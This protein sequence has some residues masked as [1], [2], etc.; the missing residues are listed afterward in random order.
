MGPQGPFFYGLRRRYA[1]RLP[2]FYVARDRGPTCS[3]PSPLDP[4][5][6]WFFCSQH[7]LRFS[8]ND[9][10]I[11]ILCALSVDIT[12]RRDRL[13]YT[14]TILGPWSQLKPIV[15]S[16]YLNHSDALKKGGRRNALVFRISD[17]SFS[18]AEKRLLAGLRRDETG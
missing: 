13:C 9:A 2:V 11:K 3:L 5:W 15:L 16:V 4:V 1:L 14:Y 12:L 10:R 18:L 8:G 6:Y 17:L 7:R